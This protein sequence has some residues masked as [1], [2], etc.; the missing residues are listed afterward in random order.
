MQSKE[1]LRLEVY[2]T[3]KKHGR[4]C[5]EGLHPLQWNVSN[6]YSKEWMKDN[7]QNDGCEFSRLNTCRIGSTTYAKPDE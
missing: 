7:I 4:Q 1:R 2:K 3:V 5:V 6:R